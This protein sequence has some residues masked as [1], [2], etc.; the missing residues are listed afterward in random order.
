MLSKIK[1]GEFENFQHGY[2]FAHWGVNSD[3]STHIVLGG[4]WK[5]YLLDIQRTDQYYDGKLVTRDSQLRWL[6]QEENER[7]YFDRDGV[8][9]FGAT[10]VLSQPIRIF[11]DGQGKPEVHKFDRVRMAD[12][13]WNGVPLIKFDGFRPEMKTWNTQWLIDNCYIIRWAAVDKHGQPNLNVRGEIR[14][15][16]WSWDHFPNNLRTDLYIPL[17]YLEGYEMYDL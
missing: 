1:A 12:G 3:V 14:Q 6:W 2:S 7:P 15:V 9:C 8:F 13:I 16:N 4:E 5:E 10:V 11:V 17:F